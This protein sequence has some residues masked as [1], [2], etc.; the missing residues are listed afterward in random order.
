MLNITID[1]KEL[2]KIIIDN[3][4][5]TKKINSLINELLLKNK[6]LLNN[7]N[8]EHLNDDEV[9]F[10]NSLISNDN[11]DNRVKVDIDKDFL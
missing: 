6:D 8:F 9:E 3:N 1:N 5:P 10:V 7:D 2:E 4:I 11:K